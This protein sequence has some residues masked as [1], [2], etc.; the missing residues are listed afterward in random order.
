MCGSKSYAAPDVLVG[1]G[2]DGEATDVWS[3][4]ICLFGMLAGFFPLDGATTTDW[5]FVRVCQA[6]IQGRSLTHTVFGFY[7]RPCPLTH[8]A[9]N[10]I[11]GMLSLNP[12]KRFTVP[13]VLGHVWNR[14]KPAPLP[15]DD[16]ENVPER[17]LPDY[18][19]AAFAPASPEM[20]GLGLQM[21]IEL[22]SCVAAA[23]NWAASREVNAYAPPVYR[24]NAAVAFALAT[25]SF[26]CFNRPP[27]AC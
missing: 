25:M 3:C 20:V 11:D 6:V 10:L 24:G 7:N 14:A 19:H 27:R 26:K 1:H 22:E 21:S 13:T 9:I 8:E 23:G 18:R 16:Q 2:Y 15:M 5:R 4:G 12:T 17:R